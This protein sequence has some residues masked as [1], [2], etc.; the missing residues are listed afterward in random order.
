MKKRRAMEK[1]PTG[2]KGT[3]LANDVGSMHKLDDNDDE[4]IFIEK[5]DWKEFL[6]NKINAVKECLW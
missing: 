4:L 5:G 3:F 2:N 6:S 1:E